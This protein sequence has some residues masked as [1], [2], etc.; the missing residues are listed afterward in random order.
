[1]LYILFRYLL[2]P[3]FMIIARPKVYNIRGLTVKGSAIYACNHIS[4]LDPAM[5]AFLSPRIVHFMAKKELFK[6]IGGLF[7][8][9]LLVFPVN[10][11][12]ADIA[13]LKQALEVLKKGRVFGIFPEGKRSVTGELDELEKGTAFLALK[14]G[15]PVIPM[16]I[17]PRSYDSPR[18]RM[19]VGE[20]V[21]CD[22]LD[23][24]SR[25]EMSDEFTK[26]LT[27]ALEG[28]RKQLEEM[29]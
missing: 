13:S 29:K 6:G 26:R 7:F 19:I 3:L 14:S 28:L 22:G 20:P 5:I 12:T 9:G 23:G 16:Y 25:G 24:M 17:D 21:S 15:A 10:R 2:W 11:H 8:R 4:M 1:M 27:A 18:F